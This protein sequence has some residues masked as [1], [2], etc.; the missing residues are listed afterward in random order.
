MSSLSLANLRL[1]LQEGAF[2][3]FH[4]ENLSGYFLTILCV[5]PTHYPAPSN[6]QL[7]ALYGANLKTVR[8]C[9]LSSCG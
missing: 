9:R 4:R 8:D 2:F 6:K 1:P 7:H 5:F 3:Q